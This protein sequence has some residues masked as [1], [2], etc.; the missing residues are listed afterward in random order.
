MESTTAIETRPVEAIIWRKDLYPRF[1]PDPATIQRYADSLDY[2]PPIEINQHNELIDG[3]HRWTAHKKMQV[4]EV[5]VTVTVTASDAE[6]LRLAIQRNAAHG[7]QLR[8]DDKKSLALKLYTGDKQAIADLLSVTYRTV[9]SWVD[10]IDRALKEERKKRIFDMWLACYP[11]RDIA[12]SVGLSEEAVRQQLAKSQ[13]LESFP[14]VGI[15]A[16]RYDDA[17]WSPPLYNIWSLAK[18]SNGTKHFGNSAQEIVDR[19]LYLY[20]QPFDIV[21]DPFAGGGSTIDVCKKRLRRYWVSDRL[22]IPERQDVRQH[23]IAEGPPSLH[24]RWQDVALMYLDPPYWR[25]A[26]NEYSQDPQDLANMSLED[27]YRALTGFVSQCAEKMRPGAHI[28]LLIQPTQWKADDRH[29]VDHVF[30]L[31]RLLTGKRLDY[32]QRIICPYATEQYNAQQV[33]WAKANKRVL[34]LNRELIV[35]KVI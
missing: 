24:K 30:D 1:E 18:L 12:E 4:A 15:L 5:L 22:P 16:A 10:S 32:E 31:V 21:V 17:G 33:E 14:K 29:M 35:W 25:Q 3:Y 6:L 13:E 8:M 28:A 34:V 9:A 26:Q 19:L 7:L 27:F 23:D 20:T 2:L 11:E